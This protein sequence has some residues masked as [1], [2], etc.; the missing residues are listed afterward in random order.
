[1]KKFFS[2]TA[3]L[4]LLIA[5]LTL[6]VCA[7]AADSEDLE[8]HLR[9]AKTDYAAG[10][11]IKATLMITNKLDFSISNLYVEILPPEG[12]ILENPDV[13]PFGESLRSGRSS[14]AAMVFCKEVI[15]SETDIPIKE[16]KSTGNTGLI[17]VLVAA[18][19]IALISTVVFL[20]LK[21]KHLRRPFLSIVLLCAMVC[22]MIPC[23]AQAR[24]ESIGR[25]MRTVSLSLTIDGEPHTLTVNLH[26]DQNE[27]ADILQID[28]QDL[29][30]REDLAAYAITE[31]FSAL[32]GTLKNPQKYAQLKLTVY[33]S[34]DHLLHIQTLP[35]AE[36]WSF[37]EIGLLPGINR[38]EITAVGQ[39]LI[40]V[41]LQLYDPYGQNYD[42]L[43]GADKDSDGEGLF[44]LL[45]NSLGTDPLLPDT[46]SDKLTDYEEVCK[47][48]T[49]PL[50]A[51]TDSNG[52]SDG[53]EDLDGDQIPNAE[54]LLLNLSP[55]LDDTDSDG[56]SDY[57]ERYIFSTDPLTADTDKDG[58]K[59]GWEVEHDYNPAS[60]N[61]AFTL[62]CETTPVSEANPVSAE[63][64]VTVSGTEVNV[65]SLSAEFVSVARN[66]F[67]SPCI[68]GYL[69]QMVDFSIDGSFE[70]ATI[71]FRYDP[72]LGTIGSNF[73]PRIYY[74]NEVTQ[75]FE[76]LENQ[77]VRN[78]VVTA[79]TSHFSS[80]ILLNKVL[81]EAVFVK[82]ETSL[83]ALC[84]EQGYNTTS[85]LQTFSTSDLAFVID[86]SASMVWNDPEQKCLEAAHFFIDRIRPGKDHI[87]LFTYTRSEEFLL[88]FIA[89]PET[90]HDAVNNIQFDN[91]INRSSGSNSIAALERALSILAKGGAGNQYILL[92]TDGEDAPSEESCQAIID[93]AVN[94][95]IQINCIGVN[96]SENTYL[97]TL[98][99]QTGG[100]CYDLNC[101]VPVAETFADMLTLFDIVSADLPDSNDDG[102][103]DFVTQLICDGILPL[104]D[105]SLEF[106]GLDLNV[107]V[108]GNPS[109]DWD[110]DGLK[111]GDELQLEMSP[112]GYPCLQMISNPTLP[113]S[114]WDGIPDSTEVLY[115]LNPLVYHFNKWEA[116]NLLKDD[117]FIHSSTLSNHYYSNYKD[118]H[119]LLGMGDKTRVDL[120][121]ALT[122]KSNRE[123]L[124]RDI[125]IRYIE[126]YG[127]QNQLQNISQDIET[128]LIITAIYDILGKVARAEK[129]LSD[130]LGLG[131]SAY[132]IL[133]SIQQV[134]SA[135][136]MRIIKGDVHKFVQNVDKLL[137]LDI[138][139]S[140][141]KKPI[142]KPRYL[143][144]APDLL[145]DLGDSVFIAVALCDLVDGIQTCANVSANNVIFSR[146]QDIL[147]EIIYGNTIDEYARQ[148]AQNLLKIMEQSYWDIT[149]MEEKDF[150]L[151]HAAPAIL[152]SILMK[153]FYTA[154]I[155]LTIK[156]CDKIYG[157]SKDL[158]QRFQTYA[159]LE[160]ARASSRL[161]LPTVSRKIDSFTIGPVT[162][163]Y[164]TVPANA[165]IEN[166]E[167]Y[168]YHAAHAHV[169]GERQ[170]YRW[171]ENDGWLPNWDR[172]KQ[173]RK[174]EQDFLEHIIKLSYRKSDYLPGLAFDLTFD[175]RLFEAP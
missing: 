74:F 13:I 46:D 59:D 107:D 26:F 113:D 128:N 2:V 142:G 102:L 148:A 70:S 105:G 87:A 170:Y 111:N 18:A 135:S 34:K 8:L 94:A 163:S 93:Q 119:A 64:K 45:E 19:G 172:T 24:S 27:Q 55:I 77:T 36:N 130:Y 42:F 43:E 37:T 1:M 3:A 39:P 173:I 41:P 81:W 149:L 91:G 143:S 133:Y 98:S 67:A 137:D 156:S 121:S 60:A 21:K 138:Q 115:G 104:K 20:L 51:D 25:Q 15:H 129:K 32:S 6:P 125:F 150:M 17:I 9:S 11:K 84:E 147:E 134:T 114:D 76:E 44:D 29:T 155:L 112:K 97:N 61:A 136:D 159:Y 118:E 22:G 85:V 116:D 110:G 12:Y 108:S 151:D 90:L 83:R 131:K 86:T 62:S 53:M 88:P 168:Y 48:F 161:L 73:Q 117:N 5:A 175:F 56:L 100:T 47:L 68:A 126:V 38:L 82:G 63:A 57:D 103:S 166:L 66:P 69:G 160:F 169:L 123:A 52:I 164:Y 145:N 49:D 157:I 140:L 54:E 127:G 16:E 152:D 146:N 89:N 109:N 95:H 162:Y 174:Q 92:F 10:E 80:Y 33:D 120:A 124:Y 78:G 50:M 99:Q 4:L 141:T 35:P 28:T 101:A 106:T 14:S 40:T 23:S 31:K 7:A 71:T 72:S 122:F 165:D 167:R 154:A 79:Q 96:I 144:A 58:A 132:D 153:N 65:E 139:I 171:M 158:D 30:Y 75:T